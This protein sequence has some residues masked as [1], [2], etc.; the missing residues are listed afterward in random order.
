MNK[1][2]TWANKKAHQIKEV[3]LMIVQGTNMMITNTTKALA[4]VV[5][6][7]TK[8]KWGKGKDNSVNGKVKQGGDK[9][10]DNEDKDR[11]KGREEEGRRRGEERK[12]K[13]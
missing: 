5:T 10:K 13:E 12:E 6:I 8:D 4:T 2:M 3:I 1:A 7:I 11:D 9:D